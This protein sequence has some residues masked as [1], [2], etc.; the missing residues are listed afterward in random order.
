MVAPSPLDRFQVDLTCGSSVRPRADVIF[1]LNP[2]LKKGQVVCNTLQAG[3]WGREEILQRMPFASGAPFELLLLALGDRFKVTALHPYQSANALLKL[4]VANR[5][6]A[7]ES[8]TY[9]AK[10]SSD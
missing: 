6:P 10:E 1:H 8:Q 7:V 5:T 9:T 3:H 2:R 4:N